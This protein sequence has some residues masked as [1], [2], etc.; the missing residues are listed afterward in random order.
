M[1]PARQAA[2]MDQPLAQFAAHAR[3]LTASS[4]RSVVTRQAPMRGRVNRPGNAGV[5][6]AP[7]A[8][9][10]VAFLDCVTAEL[11][12]LTAC[13]HVGGRSGPAPFA[14]TSPLS[15]V[16]RVAAQAMTVVSP[17]WAVQPVGP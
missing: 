11:E 4:R 7:N 14:L 12:Y 3:G 10:F 16:C 13:A 8:P 1:R 2:P 5:A 17:Y 9:S 6:S 15:H